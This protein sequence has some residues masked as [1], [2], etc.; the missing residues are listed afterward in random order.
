[1]RPHLCLGS[2]H[3]LQRRN[4][5]TAHRVIEHGD[6]GVVANALQLLLLLVFREGIRPLSRDLACK[7]VAG[8]LV[9]QMKPHHRTHSQ[10]RER[11]AVHLVHCDLND[12]C[13][14]ASQRGAAAEARQRR[15]LL[16]ASGNVGICLPLTSGNTRFCVLLRAWGN[17]RVCL[18][19]IAGLA[20]ICVLRD[21]QRR[22]GGV[23]ISAM[24]LSGF[25]AAFPTVAPSACRSVGVV[26]QL[27]T[28]VV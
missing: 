16:G 23:G 14:V 12:V 19:A 24:L 17:A 3:V 4:G 5:G 8:V 1:M 20:C 11:G 10:V 15:P 21:N 7:V 25:P 28:V 22:R 13:A 26:W 6:H 27:A 9:H 18:P 2:R